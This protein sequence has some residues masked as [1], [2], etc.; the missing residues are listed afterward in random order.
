MGQQGLLVVVHPVLPARQGVE[1]AVVALAAAEGDVDV[2]PKAGPGVGFFAKH[3]GSLL[4]NFLLY[5]RSRGLGKAG[6]DG[7]NG[8]KVVRFV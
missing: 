8:G 4:S 5:I 2:Q 1:I 3:S 7:Y 6:M